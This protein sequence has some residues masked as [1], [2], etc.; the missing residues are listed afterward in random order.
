[1]RHTENLFGWGRRIY[2][3]ERF[4]RDLGISG[5]KRIA[6]KGISVGDLLVI[7]NPRNVHD[8]EEIRDCVSA[9]KQELEADINARRRIKEGK[10]AI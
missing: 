1:M 5:S 2:L 8:L 3:K 4:R 6:L 7:Y 9:L 10:L